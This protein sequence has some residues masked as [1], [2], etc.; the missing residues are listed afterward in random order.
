MLKG[1]KNLYSYFSACLC[2]FLTALGFAILIF[3]KF[4]SQLNIETVMLQV[5]VT[6]ILM[7]AFMFKRLTAIF[8]VIPVV[9]GVAFC[10]NR[11]EINS[12]ES[13]TS[14]FN[15]LI[16]QMPQNSPWHTPQNVALIHTVVNILLC[17]VLFL[18][19]RAP[20]RSL[21]TVLISITLIL[22]VYITD[23]AEYNRIVI[24]LIFTGVCSLCAI[25]KY[26]HRKHL[27]DKKSFTVLGKG[28]IIPFTSILF[29]V[30][31]SGSTLLIFNNNERYNFRNRE[32]SQI[33]AD[34]QSHTEIYTPEQKALELSLHDLGLQKNE[35]YIG[36][37]LPEGEHILLAT[38]D[39]KKSTNVKV[40]T[41][42]RFTGKNW[43]TSF[44][45]SYRINGPFKEKQNQYLS[46]KSLK[47]PKT[48]GLVSRQKVNITL[49]VD[50][51]FLPTVGQTYK[52]TENSHTKNPILFNQSGQLFS[53]FGERNGYSYTLDTLHYNTTDSLS[54]SNLSEIT[55][56]VIKYDSTYTKD[57][58]SKYTQFP[59]KLVGDID[60]LIKQMG[61]QS[62]NRYETACKVAAFFNK[63]NGFEYSKD[64]LS[65][66]ENSSIV[67]KLLTTKK[68]HC[69]Y[70]STVTIAV[71]RHL[72]IPCRL[73]A[74]YKTVGLAKNIQIIDSYYP[75]CWVECYFPNIGWVSFDPSPENEIQFNAAQF[76]KEHKTIALKDET[77]AKK[78]EKQSFSFIKLSKTLV[79]LFI[80]LSVV[81]A[82]LIVRSF[83]ADKLYD[84]RFVA[85]RFKARN[86]QCEYYLKDIQ[87]QL[88]ALGSHKPE[89]TLREQLHPLCPILNEDE[90]ASL[91]SATEIFESYCYGGKTPNPE[92]V[93]QLCKARLILK[94][95]LKKRLNPIVYFVKRRMLLPVF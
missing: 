25:D 32:C 49:N 9:L 79:C 21:L 53:Y 70:Y 75:Y 47:F 54:K 84:Y 68:G 36:G 22:A 31:I 13:L 59:I 52:Y 5:L 29:C 38:T 41:F 89:E 27:G 67:N 51:L 43:T 48:Y 28:W 20:Y 19:W 82:Y 8:S 63:E 71:L 57:F 87:R 15:W 45:D 1:P 72:K 76:K 42:D 56:S 3:P 83:W 11:F 50:T 62:K 2:C 74:G 85:K 10:I 91:L 18:I 66:N 77:T 88:Y 78:A 34:V 6:C 46:N 64:G 23:A 93:Q 92:E 69:V 55:K 37:N 12:N 33:A 30:L 44:T 17:V 7:S 58:V 80:A 95:L 4:E 35:K 16:N 65:F 14:F 94:E 90:K 60:I 40:T 24:L 61:I 39:L 26:E 86:E 73:A 81:F